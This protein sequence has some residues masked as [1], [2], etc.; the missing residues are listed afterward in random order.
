MREMHEIPEHQE[1]DFDMVFDALTIYRHPR[2]QGYT[3]S[4]AS[5]IWDGMRKALFEKGYDVENVAELQVRAEYIL[6]GI[7]ELERET[8]P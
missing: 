1:N 4:E 7:G 5:A 8:R 2:A 6:N 3:L